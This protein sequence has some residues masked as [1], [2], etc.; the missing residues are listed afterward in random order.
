EIPILQIRNLDV[1]YGP[2]QVLFGVDLDVREGEVLA[3]LGTNG[4]GKSTVLRAVSG[5]NPTDRGVGRFRGRDMTFTAPGARA[6]AGIGQMAGGMSVFADMTVREKLRAGAFTLE[7][8]VDEAIRRTLEPLPVL[9]ERLEQPAGSLS[10]GEQQMLGLA[11][12]M[13]LEPELLIIDE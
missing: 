8:D 3:L 5:L 12:A 9:A 2:V 6:R 1:S 11:K 13:L 4:A 10:G 7:G